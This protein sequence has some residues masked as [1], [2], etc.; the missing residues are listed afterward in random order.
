MYFKRLSEKINS[1]SSGVLIS[2]ML[3]SCALL[4][5]SKSSILKNSS[6]L[7]IFRNKL[8]SITNNGENKLTM[9]SSESCPYC[10]RQ[11]T[12]FNLIFNNNL[13]DYLKIDYNVPSG[14]NGIPHFEMKTPNGEVFT[15]TG[16]L[17]VINE[18]ESKWLGTDEFS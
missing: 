11:K 13:P 9:Y 17:F 15:H 14:I 16:S 1:T 5:Y 12:A 8:S 10:V 7:N 3:L 2:V 4:F 18:T 6:E